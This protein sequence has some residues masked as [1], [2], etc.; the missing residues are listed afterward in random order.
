MTEKVT[1][2]P[3]QGNVI[4]SNSLIYIRYKS[5]VR[6]KAFA[7]LFTLYS[8]QAIALRDFSPDFC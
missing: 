5:N 1:R 6:K 4:F 2:V 3:C 7:A 8:F